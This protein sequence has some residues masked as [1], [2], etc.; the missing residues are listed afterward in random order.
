MHTDYTGMVHIA[1]IN[2][3][4]PQ[5]TNPIALA[6]KRLKPGL[7]DILVKHEHRRD[8]T[9]VYLIDKI[10]KKGYNFLDNPVIEDYSSGSPLMFANRYRKKIYLSS[11][12]SPEFSFVKEINFSRLLLLEYLFEYNGCQDNIHRWSIYTRH[13]TMNAL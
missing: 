8:K 1:D 6:I 13:F 7:Q 5:R 3:P 9:S 4:S 12:G 10:D 11:K 2:I